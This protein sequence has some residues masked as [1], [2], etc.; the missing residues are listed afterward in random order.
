MPPVGSFCN[1]KMAYYFS[2]QKLNSQIYCPNKENYVGVETR[3]KKVLHVLI[4]TLCPLPLSCMRQGL[5]HPRFAWN[6]LCID[7]DF[8]LL[9]LLNAGI[10]AAWI[11]GLG[12]NPG[13]RCLV[14]KDSTNRAT[15][16]AHSFL[17]MGSVLW[18]RRTL[19]ADSERSRLL[20]LP[21]FV[22]HR[23]GEKSWNLVLGA[24]VVTHRVLLLSILR[25][26]MGSRKDCEGGA[27][28]QGKPCMIALGTTC[29][30]P[31]PRFL[32]LCGSC[33]TTTWLTT[34]VG[35]VA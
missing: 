8:E 12:L 22:L 28:S 18:D 3:R 32:F 5:M 2:I 7:D 25:K 19:L 14:G 29:H 20:P 30:L 15:S 21:V 10:Q 26:V 27:G 23:E 24:V 16:S 17:F 1:V 9:I 6:S 34:A 35:Q 13:L 33:F 11:I 31:F 4:V